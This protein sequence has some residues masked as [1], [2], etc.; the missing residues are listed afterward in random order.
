MSFWIYIKKIFFTF[1]IIV[2][3]Y[4]C[5]IQPT[6]AAGGIVAIFKGITKLF[7]GSGD[8]IVNSA[9][10]LIR[11]GKN[12]IENFGKGND[13]LLKDIKNKQ[14]G[15]AANNSDESLILEKIGTETHTSEFK[16]LKESSRSDYI[17]KIRKSEID[18]L[19]DDDLLEF[20]ESINSG[21]DEDKFKE[22]VILNWI[23]K[24]YRVSNYFNKPVFE[25]KSLLVCKNVD[26][27][28]YIALLMEKEPRRAIL[29]KHEKFKENIKKI[30]S[31]ELFIIEDTNKRKIMTTW[32]RGTEFPEHYFVI[33]DNQNFY[34]ENPTSGKIGPDKFKFDL[35]YRKV[36]ENKCFKATETGLL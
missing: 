34:Y 22:L 12:Q 32:P 5:L 35:N 2:S 9:D 36:S 17:A 30:P 25:E 16:N 1:L 28:F 21:S 31:Q 26:Q 8:N 18:N 7:T 20:F 11:K 14:I 10:D 19:M 6:Y 33:Y 13:D 15:N 24:I 23:G 4:L 27:V 3:F 29:T